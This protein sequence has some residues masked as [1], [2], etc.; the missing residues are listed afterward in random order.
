MYEEGVIAYQL[1]SRLATLLDSKDKRLLKT[2]LG[3]VKGKEGLVRSL[4]CLVLGGCQEQLE[5]V[6]GAELDLLAE[7]RSRGQSD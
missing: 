3:L 1:D 5:R 2:G 6:G 7:R 4:R